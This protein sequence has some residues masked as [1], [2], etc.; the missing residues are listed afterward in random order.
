MNLIA[1]IGWLWMRDRRRRLVEPCVIH[2]VDLDDMQGYRRRVKLIEWRPDQAL[3]RAD[4]HYQV[5]GTIRQPIAC[6]DRLGAITHV[7]LERAGLG[8]RYAHAGDI[9]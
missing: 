8:G 2:A 5:A 6:R 7:G 9:G 1:K 3:G 4:I